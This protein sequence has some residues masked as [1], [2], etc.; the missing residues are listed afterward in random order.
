[1]TL[2]QLIK[3]LN[4]IAE[5]NPDALGL[6]VVLPPNAIAALWGEPHEITETKY[7]PKRGT[8]LSSQ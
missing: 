1:M 5:S 6:P 3:Q 7:Y 4:V 2:R 8:L